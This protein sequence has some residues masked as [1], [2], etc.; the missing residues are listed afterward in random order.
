[1]KKLET[2]SSTKVKNQIVKP[3]F[4]SVS[5]VCVSVK[6]FSFPFSVLFVS[7]VH[8]C[9]LFNFYP[10]DITKISYLEQGRR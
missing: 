1:M 5:L 8:V 3:V 2:P 6:Q 9:G 10:T 4:L 7:A